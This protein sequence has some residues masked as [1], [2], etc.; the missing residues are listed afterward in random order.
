M[1][2]KKQSQKIPPSSTSS[3]KAINI[4]STEEMDKNKDKSFTSPSISSFNRKLNISNNKNVDTIH[5][6]LSNNNFSNNNRKKISNILGKKVR[7]KI[8][9]QKKEKDKEKEKEENLSQNKIIDQYKFQI[10]Q[11]LNS[12]KNKDLEISLL[13]KDLQKAKSKNSKKFFENLD[14]D[15]M[16][17]KILATKKTYKNF[18]NKN[19]FTKDNFRIQPIDRIVIFNESNSYDYKLDIES[20]DSI[21]ILPTVKTPLQAQII[22]QMEIEPLEKIKYIQI[23]DQ[24]EIGGKDKID[25]LE[26]EERDS[27]EILPTEKAPLKA[28]ITSEMYIE[29]M[30]LPDF[31]IQNIDDINILKQNKID[32]NKVIESKDRIQIFSVPKKPLQPQHTENMA[33]E[34]NEEDSLENITQIANNKDIGNTPRNQEMKKLRNSLEHLPVKKSPL[35]MKNPEEMKYKYLKKNSSENK[36]FIKYYSENDDLKIDYIE[37]VNVCNIKYKPKSNYIYYN[38]S[39]YVKNGK[40]SIKP[41]LIIKNLKNFS[42]SIKNYNNHKVE[43]ISYKNNKYN[44]NNLIKPKPSILPVGRISKIINV[45][46]YEKKKGR[47]YNTYTDERKK[48]NYTF[49]NECSSK[50]RDVKVI[51]TQKH[52]P[53]IVEKRFI[54]HSCEKCNNNYLNFK[55]NNIKKK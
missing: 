25:D 5:I 40:S 41:T 1:L 12:L 2:L 18:M 35:H 36:N 45:E 54:A 20:R 43:E 28:Q 34:T 39:N 15:G 27:I 47:N 48:F 23:L 6:T 55:K 38:Y 52:G 33:I 29:R 37:S 3:Q 50:G 26:I 13:K 21:E 49:Y 8:N 51:K 22:A 24:I 7:L 42:K 53:S 11:L 30:T 19:S 14:I 46:K 32:N 16:G 31:L 4:S 9:Q 10:N 44:N 17:I